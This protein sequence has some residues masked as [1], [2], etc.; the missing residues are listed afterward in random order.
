MRGQRTG[1]GSCAPAVVRD[2]S[3]NLPRQPKNV[4]PWHGRAQNPPSYRSVMATVETGVNIP[5]HSQPLPVAA[6]LSGRDASLALGNGDAEDG[7]VEAQRSS[8]PAMNGSADDSTAEWAELELG[9]F[10]S[11]SKE[12]T[13][14]ASFVDNSTTPRDLAD[15]GAPSTTGEADDQQESRGGVGL[16]E[17]VMGAAQELAYH[18]LIPGVSE[19]AAAVSILVTLFSDGR[20]LNSGYDTNLKQCR[21]IILMLERAAKVAGKVR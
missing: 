3:R 10:A 1:A 8:P 2:G 18:C 17:A 16:G 12:V 6:V 20:D 9:Q 19:A 4:L 7:G 5:D 15:N 21:S 14:E 13:R 11:K